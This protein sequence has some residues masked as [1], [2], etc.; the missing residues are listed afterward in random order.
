MSL[1]KCPNS[2][3]PH[4]CRPDT[5]EKNGQCSRCIKYG[6]ISSS[7]S[8]VILSSI[9]LP[10]TPNKSS[11]ISEQKTPNISEKKTPNT[12]SN[13]ENTPIDTRSR[14]N[15]GNKFSVDLWRIHIGDTFEGLCFCGTVLTY[16]N[17]HIGHVKAFADGGDESINNTIPICMSCNLA[18]KTTNMNEYYKAKYNIDIS[19][20]DRKNPKERQILE[21]RAQFAKLSMEM[22]KMKEIIE[23]L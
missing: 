14:K 17:F 6:K 20:V 12:T 23:S 18:M 22:K 7:V 4:R 8:P 19:T 1:I 5:F 9:T 16:P 2:G 3:C 13:K 10:I 21:L 11:D 15:L